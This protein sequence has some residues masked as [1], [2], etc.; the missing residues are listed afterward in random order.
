MWIVAYALR[1]RYTIGVLAILIV[2]FGLFSGRRMSTDILPPV[3]IPSLNLVWIYSG[4]DARE[5]ATRVTSFSEL[6]TINNVDN[7]REIRSETTAGLAVVKIDFQPYV[8][9]DTAMAQ[10]VAVSQ[11]I[12]RRMP[13]GMQ[14]PLIVRYSQSSTP[15]LQLTLSSDTLSESQLFDFARIQLRSQ[16][17]TIPGIRLT[18]PYGG[19]ARQVMIDLNPE[20]L[21]A[22]GLSAA[23][24][25]RAVSAQNLVLP[26]G[27]VR[28]PGREM[29]VSVNA[30]PAEVAAFQDL[31]IREVGGRVILL[32]DVAA[33][34]DGSTVQTNVARLNGQNGVIVSIL[35]LG[36]ASTVDIVDQ[37]IAR[38]PEIRAGAPKGLTIEPIFDQSVFVR[39]AIDAVVKEAVLVAL[40]VAAVVLVFL[41]SKRSTLIVLTS[42]PLA[43]LASV[44]GLHAVGHTFNLMTLGGLA[45]AIGILVDNALVEI[46]NIN[47][48]LDQ[49]KPLQQAI[50]DSARQVAFP[51]FVSTLCICIVF[52]P[53][54]LL[55]GV[56]SYVFAPLALS[57]VFAMAASYLL[58]RT[59]VPTLASLLLRDGG[60]RRAEQAA[61]RST[62]YLA[63]HAA[64][65]VLEALRDTYRQRFARL[66]VHRLL[67]G[68]GCAAVIGVGVFAAWSLGREFFPAADAG[69]MRL[70]LRAPPGT[71]LEDTARQF[72]EVQRDI[73][74]IVPAQELRFIG[75]SIGAV[76]P[77]NRG[78][79]ESVVVG[80][81][82]GELYIQLAPEHA[83]TARYMT[84]IR[85]MLKEKYPDLHA[86]FRPADNISQ[87]LAG[88][89]PAALEVRFVGRAVPA[90]LKLARELEQRLAQVPGAVDVGLLQVLD[91]PEYF[92]E[93]D[94]VRAM[95]IGVTQQ[96]AT[97]AI[98]GVLGSGGTVA[99]S[100]WADGRMGISYNVQVHQPPISLT[101]LEQLLNTPVRLSALGEPVLLRTIARA[102]ERR[103]PALL[104]RVTL[105]PSLNVVANVEG[106][107]LGSV[108]HEVEALAGEL[109]GKLE[110]GNRIEIVGQSKAMQS[111]Y[112]ELAGGIGIAAVLVFLVMVV[113][114][115]SW[116][117]PAVALSGLPFA[118]T[119]AALALW[120]TATPL[121]VPA[122]MGMIMV[123]GV[124]TANSVLVTSFALSRLREGT[125][126]VQ[127]ATEAAATRLR[128]VLMTASAMIVGVL[129]MA[130]G[131]GEGGEQNAPLG[132]A[133]VGGLL[134]GTVATLVVVP[135]VFAL[136]MGGHRLAPLTRS[137]DAARP[138][139]G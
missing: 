10:A 73:R 60:A 35:K 122:L 38:L 15:I 3:D 36:G 52:I 111:A 134:L 93:V 16:I 50:L 91:L 71:R 79:V 104:N 27:V 47:R 136:L 20:A 1:R 106:R 88:T 132:R 30:S 110:P 101:S 138:A 7:V 18:L 28:E 8:N 74:A 37:V 130:L 6:A 55:T 121:S 13:P 69:L 66:L 108:Y 77:I 117:A 44:A 135:A 80:S 94:R 63:H 120:A 100:M 56:A 137:G 17:Q 48:N 90:N 54:F 76:E 107:D 112:A 14:P 82:D 83:P 29:Q 81:F 19:A 89:S 99:Q 133:V 22:Y 103:V 12:L 59:L 128:A 95:Q 109:R 31:P 92:I 78:W 86:F 39:A 32:R 23:D 43:L 62:L 124:S 57:V 98:L 116:S 85:R 5:M 25:T 45:L 72:A 64:E 102:S 84:R 97:N 42:I 119:G 87:T 129:P 33:V 139:V 34:R 65:G 115:Q 49:G 40:L 118:L 46:E 131:L 58:S 9:V 4:L 26:S 96:E 68:L 2:L 41:G 11:T 21:Q 126:A 105:A 113:N 123:V 51:E 127:A 70:Y 125:G 67:L 24:V 114:F 53:V 75:E 61:R